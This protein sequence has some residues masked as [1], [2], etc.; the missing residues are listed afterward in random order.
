MFVTLKKMNWENV[1][2]VSFRSVSNASQRVF[3][4]RNHDDLW[5]IKGNDWILVSS[6]LIQLFFH[7]IYFI[8]D[9]LIK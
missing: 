9:I 7:Y 1:K 2:N 8:I 6:Y 5:I 4:H 3:R